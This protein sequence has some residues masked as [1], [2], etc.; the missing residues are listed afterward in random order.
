MNK[1][2]SVS[3]LYEAR[4]VIREMEG[5]EARIAELEAQVRELDSCC[6]D[7]SR[8]HS[9]D[10]KNTAALAEQLVQMREALQSAGHYAI[11]GDKYHA[12]ETI[13][14]ALDLSTA[15]AEEVLRQHDAKVIEQVCQRFAYYDGNTYADQV[16]CDFGLLKRDEDGI[17]IP[18]APSNT[19][20]GEKG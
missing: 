6:D 17:P 11:Y 15:T 18:A 2:E 14:A 5:Q 9:A 1:A 12:R 13:E 10:L 7:Y 16:R 8:M 4:R 20:A 3:T 19:A